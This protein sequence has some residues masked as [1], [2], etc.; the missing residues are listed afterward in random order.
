M[1]GGA[2]ATTVNVPETV[3]LAPRALAEVI[4]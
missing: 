4:V 3:V 2:G 1:V